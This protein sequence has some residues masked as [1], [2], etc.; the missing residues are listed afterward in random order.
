MR[1]YFISL[2]IIYF[3]GA[4]SNTSEFKTGEIKTLDFLRQTFVQSKVARSWINSRNLL[5][6]KQIDSANIP[7]LFVELPTGQNG[8]LTP[9]P[10]QGDGQTWLGADGATITLDR[11]VLKASRGMGDD[12]MGSLNSMP[13]WTDVNQ[14][15]KTYIRKLKYITGNNNISERELYCNILKINEKEV[16]YI[17]EVEFFVTK[18]EETCTNNNFQ[19][20][21]TYYLDELKI[22]RKSFQYHSDTIGY[23]DIERLDR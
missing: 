21:N 1:I 19:I 15:A 9:Y 20:K 17:W 6:R 12:L 2:I 13:S 4:C 10:G 11:G 3:L 8:T 7:I 16:L 22:V 18:F 23:I 5:S 14:S